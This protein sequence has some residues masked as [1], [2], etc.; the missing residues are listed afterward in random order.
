MIIVLGVVAAL[1]V[2]IVDLNAPNPITIGD[3]SV[4]IDPQTRELELLPAD[5]DCQELISEADEPCP[6]RYAFRPDTTLIA[7]ISV[8]N[9]GPISLNLRGISQG[10][11]DQY[12]DV[13]PLG[14]PIRALDGGDPQHGLEEVRGVP[15]EPMV[16]DSGDERI[17]GIE[18]RTTADKAYACEHY[19][20]GGGVAWE[21]APIAWR[22]L[23]AE[24]EEE[25]D[26]AEP[27]VF[28]APTA[29]DCA[30]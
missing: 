4:G 11:L 9:D 17:V 25:F 22:W 7:W 2:V 28:M 15:F 29:D 12:T 10:W 1:A 16:L 6:R 8:R 24:H 30:A 13:K 14:K 20:D 23:F 26:F 5:P 19:E 27:I 3:G 18:F 21:F